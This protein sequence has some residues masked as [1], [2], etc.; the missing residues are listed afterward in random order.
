MKDVSSTNV[1]VYF[2]DG[3]PTD[4]TK[5]TSLTFTPSFVSVSP[6]TGGSIGGT[7]VTVT[8]TGF[9]INTKD[10]GLKKG[11]SAFCQEVKVTGYGKFT[12]LTTSVSSLSTDV[13]KFTILTTEYACAN[14]DQTLCSL[15]Q[16]S[17]TSPKI[18]TAALSGNTLT[19]TGTLF[20]SKDT[21]SAKAVFKSQSVVVTDWTETGLVATFTKGVPAT[22]SG[23]TDLP[24]IW[25]TRNSDSVILITNVNGLTFTNSV[26]VTNTDSSSG[27]QSSFA[28]GVSYTVTKDNVFA[29]LKEAG[30]G[31]TVCGNPA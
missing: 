12:C 7:L 1:Q 15:S 21:H 11:T 6:N 2:A 28:G 24:T 19:F 5:T 27:V 29:T 30:N 13:L 31:M 9:G 22:K 4:Y 3:N 18:D 10:L 26:S 14:T 23:D 16:E 17:A 8:G 25:F 20:P